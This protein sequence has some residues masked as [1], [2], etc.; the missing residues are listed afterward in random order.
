MQFLSDTQHEQF[1]KYLV[2]SRYSVNLNLAI[3]NIL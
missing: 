3:Y 2:Y 1:S